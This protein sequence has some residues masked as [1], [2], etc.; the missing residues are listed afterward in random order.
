MG[1]WGTSLYANDAASDIRNDYIDKLKC[2]KTNEEAIKELVEENN[3]IMGD[4]EEEPLF[5]FALADTQWEYGR[6]MPEVKEKALFYLAQGKELER[7]NESGGKKINDWK[8]KLNVLMEKLKSPQPPEKKVPKYS[9]Y[10]CEW[11][12]GD[13]FAYRFA[14]NYSKEKGLEGKYAIFRKVS[15]DVWWPGHIIPVIQ[16]YRWI[17]SSIPSIDKLSDFDLLPAFYSPSVFEKFPE[18]KIE[19]KIKLIIE[20]EKDIPKKNLV[21]LGN[22]PGKDVVPLKGCDYW[23]GYYAVGWESGKYNVKFERYVIDTYLAW[24]EK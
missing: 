22:L 3:Q 24:K 2:G 8:K 18:K 23:T 21:F 13:V 6:L 10:Q 1:A 16:V 19:Y 15:E 17:G 11:K 20:A 14:S 5:W 12:L 4:T 9:L 7:W